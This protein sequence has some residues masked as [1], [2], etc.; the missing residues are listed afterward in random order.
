MAWSLLLPEAQ[1]AVS[2]ECKQLYAVQLVILEVFKSKIHGLHS[3]VVLL[4]LKSLEKMVH[5]KCLSETLDFIASE[6]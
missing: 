2:N 6:A 5:Q 3:G 4:R 1:K